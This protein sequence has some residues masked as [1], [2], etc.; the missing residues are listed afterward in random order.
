LKVI[1][2]EI[3]SQRVTKYPIDS[4]FQFTC[5]ISLCYDT[6]MLLLQGRLVGKGALHQ[7]VT[8][9]LE[10]RELNQFITVSTVLHGL[11]TILLD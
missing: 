7:E 8:L 11:L 6:G 5:P 9:N 1:E 10:R 2:E 3:S 4:V